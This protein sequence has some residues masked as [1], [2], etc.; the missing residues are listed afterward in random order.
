MPIYEFEY[1]KCGK[2]FEDLV[3]H[4]GDISPCPKCGSKRVD[5]LVSVTAPHVSKGE[6]SMPSCADGTCNLP[7]CGDGTCGFG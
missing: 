7:P 1:R 6:S 4:R 2:K 3:P 5:R